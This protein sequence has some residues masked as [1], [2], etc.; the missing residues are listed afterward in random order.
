MTSP[1]RPRG[2]SAACSPRSFC[3]PSGG[4]RP[5]TSR[6]PSPALCPGSVRRLS[7]S[8]TSLESLHSLAPVQ[9]AH[10]PLPLQA[11]A[12]GF[13]SAQGLEPGSRDQEPSLAVEAR[14]WAS[15]LA[16]HPGGGLCPR[17]TAWAPLQPSPHFPQ[18]PGTS[19]DFGGPWQ[20]A[21]VGEGGPGRKEGVEA[22]R[23]C[24]PPCLPASLPASLPFSSLHSSDEELFCRPPPLPGS[25]A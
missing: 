25:T 22:P 18:A 8:V 3:S 13:H 15:N 10:C 14:G 7:S 12:L 20:Q 24:P 21:Q 5:A 9:R 19:R 23:Q 4:G 2:P 11:P 1:G 17:S 16:T 6:S